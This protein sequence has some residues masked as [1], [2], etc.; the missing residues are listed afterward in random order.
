LQVTGEK[1]EG[2]AGTTLESSDSSAREIKN[3]STH[4]KD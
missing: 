3:Q 1:C 4:G 2:K